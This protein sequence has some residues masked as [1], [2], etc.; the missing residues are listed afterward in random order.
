[1]T[2]R[3][4]SDSLRHKKNQAL[5]PVILFGGVILLTILGFQN[6]RRNKIANPG[7]YSNQDEIPG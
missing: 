2:S 3:R 1:M 4:R 7:S 6:I 5:L